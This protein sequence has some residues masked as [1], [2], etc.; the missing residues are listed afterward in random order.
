MA[1]DYLHS[2]KSYTTMK[3]RL[4]R[5][6][7]LQ[8]LFD[9]YDHIL[10]S[11][12]A[13]L[14]EEDRNAV[15]ALLTFVLYGVSDT[16]L[17]LLG[18]RLSR[19]AVA[20][21]FAASAS[22][23]ESFFDAHE[24][25]AMCPSFVC[26]RQFPSAQ[27]AQGADA[28]FQL[29]HFS[30]RDYLVSRRPELYSAGNGEAYLATL[31]MQSFIISD[32][33]VEANA[34]LEYGAH[35]WMTHPHQWYNLNHHDWSSTASCGGLQAA[36]DA[37]L[38]NEPVS[39]AFKGWYDYWARGDHTNGF[40]AYECSLSSSCLVLDLRPTDPRPRLEGFLLQHRDPRRTSPR[41]PPAL[42]EALRHADC[43]PRSSSLRY[44][45][46]HMAQA[47]WCQPHRTGCQ[48]VHS[49]RI[50]LQP[51]CPGTEHPQSPANR[52]DGC[53]DTAAKRRE[54]LYATW[55]RVLV[56]LSARLPRL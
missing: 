55:Q 47:T 6:T 25:V 26:I 4:T 36:L 28:H 56:P 50:R 31:C 30:V 12:M 54:A 43:T 52:P 17:S 35:H 33:L 45:R 39:P 27:D 13:E 15:R 9:I 7:S 20:A 22:W 3:R 42:P 48:G 40:H 5:L 24:L 23:P 51:R 8:N 14:D 38:L 29:A 10:D 41:R 49:L 53:A 18:G 37:F 2:S 32:G 44:G 21:S 46:T 16:N 19:N 11:M 34:F 1:Q